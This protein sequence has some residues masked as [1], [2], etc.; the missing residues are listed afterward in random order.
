[1]ICAGWHSLL[2]GSSLNDRTNDPNRSFDRPY[3]LLR[4]NLFS[5][6]SSPEIILLSRLDQTMSASDTYLFKSLPVS[7]ALLS[8][9]LS[10][11]LSRFLSLSLSLSLSL[12]LHCV[13]TATARRVLTRL[14]ERAS[15]YV[16]LHIA[17]WSYPAPGHRLVFL[18]LLVR[19]L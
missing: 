12:L 5:I 7:V 18:Y 19:F 17:P 6:P 14:N 16:K 8:L 15:D 11:S 10:L 1:M 9:S 13:I 2:L 4:P 3:N